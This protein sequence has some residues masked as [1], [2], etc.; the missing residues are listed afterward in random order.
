M[1]CSPGGWGG[2]EGGWCPDNLFVAHLTRYN[3][4]EFQLGWKFKLRLTSNNLYSNT[5]WNPLFC[6]VYRY[7]VHIVHW[8]VSIWKTHESL[9]FVTSTIMKIYFVK[10]VIEDL[11][12]NNECLGSSNFARK[13][14]NGSRE[15]SFKRKPFSTLNLRN[16]SHYS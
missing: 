7:I 15:R 13:F 4:Q 1:L 9:G 10:S 12:N 3:L 14:G 6:R 11:P 16:F 5:W 8:Q 2:R